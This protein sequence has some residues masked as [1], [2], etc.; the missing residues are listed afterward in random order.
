MEGNYANLATVI[1]TSQTTT[2]NVRKIHQGI[3]FMSTSFGFK[4]FDADLNDPLG[5]LIRHIFVHSTEI[6]KLK[7]KYSM[8]VFSKSTSWRYVIQE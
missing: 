2:R 6:T 7:L 8:P 5:W 3:G 4:S 1:H